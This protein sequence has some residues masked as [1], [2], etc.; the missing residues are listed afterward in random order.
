MTRGVRMDGWDCSSECD[1]E[2]AGRLVGESTKCQDVFVALNHNPCARVLI[3]K[4]M[5]HIYMSG[6]SLVLIIKK[7]L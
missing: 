3:K 7:T 2:K 6:G 1:D 5:R 4:R